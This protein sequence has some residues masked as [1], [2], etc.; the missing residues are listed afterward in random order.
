MNEKYRNRNEENIMW[1]KTMS[2][3]KVNGT[4]RHPE[5]WAT[6]NHIGKMEL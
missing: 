6:G 3:N 4:R 5:E 1:E 2:R